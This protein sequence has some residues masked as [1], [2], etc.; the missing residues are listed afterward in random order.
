[1][2]DNINLEDIEGLQINYESKSYGPAIMGTT[3]GLEKTPEQI[4]IVN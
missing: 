2:G 3:G 4:N 1:M